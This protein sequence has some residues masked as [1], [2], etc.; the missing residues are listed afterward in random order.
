M[1]FIFD[2]SFITCAISRNTGS[3]AKTPARPSPLSTSINILKGRA[4]SGERSEI[5]FIVSKLSETSFMSAPDFANAST[6]SSL[7]GRMPTAY[8]MSLNPLARKYSASAKVETVTPPAWPCVT[9]R[10]ISADFAVFR[11]GRKATPRRC[12]RECIAS[13]FRCRA[14]RSKISAG[15]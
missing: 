3:S 6:L 2:A 5:A 13:R 1:S 10:A 12:I 15:V 4:L 9:N 11:C 7:A 8:R 14:A